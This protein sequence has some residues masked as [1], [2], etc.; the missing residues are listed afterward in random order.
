MNTTK[1]PAVKAVTTT[2]SDREIRMERI[3]NAPRERVWKAMTDAGTA[4]AVVGTRQQACARAF[5]VRAR[6]P[7]ALRRAQRAGPEGFDGRFGGDLT[8]RP[9]RHVADVLHCAVRGPRHPDSPGTRRG[10]GHR[11]RQGARAVGAVREIRRDAGPRGAPVATDVDVNGLELPEGVGPLDD[12]DRTDV[13]TGGNRSG[14]PDARR[15]DAERDV[16]EISV[17]GIACRADSHQCLPAMT[18][19]TVTSWDPVLAVAD[20]TP[21]ASEL[22][23][24]PLSPLKSKSN[25]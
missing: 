14:D 21:V 12:F 3:F 20:G 11:P 23:V 8:H 10:S 24:A 22:H 1:E 18:D 9:D 7:L 19:G 6:R 2:P 13:P 5:R 17:S 15:I 16:A 25:V 4:G